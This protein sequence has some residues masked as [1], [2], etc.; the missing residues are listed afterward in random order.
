MQF[1]KSP[2]RKDWDALEKAES[3]MR[4]CFII[5]RYTGY[6]IIN[7]Q[8]CMQVIGYWAYSFRGLFENWIFVRKFAKSDLLYSSFL[9]S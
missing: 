7:S 1:F 9:H 6:T 4:L 3:W 8:Q 2:T 5:Y